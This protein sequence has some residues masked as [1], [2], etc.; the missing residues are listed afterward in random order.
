[1][2]HR[3]NQTSL[4]EVVKLFKH[5]NRTTNLHRVTKTQAE[6]NRTQKQNFR[7]PEKRTISTVYQL[8]LPKFSSE[9]I[10]RTRTDRT[11][12]KIR[13]CSVLVLSVPYPVLFWFSQ[14]LTLFCSGSLSS[15]PCSVFGSLKFQ[16][17]R[18]GSE[19][20]QTELNRPTLAIPVPPAGGWWVGGG[21]AHSNSARPDVNKQRQALLI[22]V[23]SIHHHCPS[24]FVMTTGK[25]FFISSLFYCY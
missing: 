2:I 1:V 19:P 17:I 16:I 23:V 12:P 13:F 10:Q 22:N 25:V 3:T 15:L 18:T 24:S 11:E 6:Q 14:F 4:E 20:V 8:V 7:S 21:S 9:L 5:R